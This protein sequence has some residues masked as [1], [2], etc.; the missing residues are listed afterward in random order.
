M[1][2]KHGMRHAADGMQPAAVP[3]QVLNVGMMML[4]NLQAP[5]SISRLTYGC[6]SGH[7]AVLAYEYGVPVASFYAASAGRPVDQSV[8]RGL[9]AAASSTQQAI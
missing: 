1:G 9:H 7:E 3:R 4:R 6:C 5:S 2:H 8:F